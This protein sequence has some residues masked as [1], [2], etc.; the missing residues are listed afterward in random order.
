[1]VCR[2]AR[3]GGRTGRYSSRDT[4]LGRLFYRAWKEKEGAAIRCEK[5]TAAVIKIETMMA[6]SYSWNEGRLFWVRNAGG[7]QDAVKED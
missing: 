1:M 5:E 2:D 6:C 7:E 4:V 3:R